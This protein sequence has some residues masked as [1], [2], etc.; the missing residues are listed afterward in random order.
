[1]HEDCNVIVNVFDVQNNNIIKMKLDDVVKRITVRELPEHFEIE[2]VKA[3]AIAVRT[4]IVKRLKMFDGMSSEDYKGADISTSMKGCRELTDFNL[5]KEAVGSDFDNMYEL[6]CRA[7]EDTSGLIITCG[8]RPILA[9]YHLSCGGGTENS[10]DVLGNT[11]MYF[12]KVL[13]K[14][15]AGSPH[16]ESTVDITVKELEEKLDTKLSQDSSIWGP[17]IEGIIDDIERDDTG[18]VRKIKIGGRYFTGREIRKLLSLNSSRFG[19][20]PV[21]IRFKI[22]GH[23]TGLGMCLY[24]A[25]VMARN[26]STFEEILNYYY[27]NITIEKIDTAGA[28]NPLRGKVFVIDPGH[29]GELGDDEAG[30]SGLREKDVNLYIAQR[31]AEY[32]EKNG[33]SVKLTR[34]TDEDISLPKRVE[35]INNI[36]PNF[37]ISIHQNSFFAPGVSG[38]EVYFYRGDIEGEKMGKNILNNIVKSMGTVNRGNRNADF[39][40]LRESKVS[41]V[42]VECMYISNP[43]EERKLRCD[44]IKMI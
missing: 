11:I 3:L 14:Y 28:G 44:E 36:R 19:W 39:Y 5:L 15:C 23:G 38:T 17:K 33:A 31:L 12:R 43:E 21:V 1:V 29:G 16:W 13:C 6:S 4:S 30:P 2:A 7:A 40:I 18:R 22:R 32:L 27:T 20:D 9:D 24:G 26:G 34:Y 35:M 25:N 42:L 37:V 41:S 10:E 8:G